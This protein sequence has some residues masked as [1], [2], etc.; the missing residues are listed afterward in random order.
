LAHD[1][2]LFPYNSIFPIPTISCDDVISA[3]RPSGAA[4]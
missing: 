2:F 3:L 1:I 4:M